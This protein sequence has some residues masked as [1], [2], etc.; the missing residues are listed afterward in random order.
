MDGVVPSTKG[1]TDLDGRPLTNHE[2]W[3]QGVAV[4]TFE[5]GDGRFVYEQVAIHDGWA[6]WRGRHYKAEP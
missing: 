5:E 1:G 6:A 2:D 3:Q 4:V